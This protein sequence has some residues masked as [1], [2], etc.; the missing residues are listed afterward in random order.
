MAATN[1]VIVSE[2]TALRSEVKSLAKLVRKIRA[3]QEDPTGE[4]AKERAA[5]SG[6]NK[7]QRVSPELAAF[8]GLAEGEGI[9]RGQVTSRISKYVKENNLKDPNNGRVII[10]DDKLKSILKDV[11]EGV[12]IKITNLQTY[13]KSHYIGLADED[14]PAE[15]EPAT[16]PPAK[17]VVKRPVVKKAAA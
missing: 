7:L 8:L 3:T 16:P 17:K 15:P 13:I 10:L 11:P 14:T 12:D 9:S 4:K 1:D 2:L 5:R 6:F